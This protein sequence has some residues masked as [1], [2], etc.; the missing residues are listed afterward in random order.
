MRSDIDIFRS[1]GNGARLLS[2]LRRVAACDRLSLDVHSYVEGY[3]AR[4]H[5][6]GESFLFVLHDNF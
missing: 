5:V 2:L 1:R 6:V 3:L 4:S